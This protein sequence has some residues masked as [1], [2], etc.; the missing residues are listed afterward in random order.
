MQLFWGRHRD[1]GPPSPEGARVPAWRLTDGNGGP[2]LPQDGVSSAVNGLGSG[3]IEQPSNLEFPEWTRIGIRQVYAF[4]R[5]KYAEAYF[6]P[7]AG[8]RAKN[9]A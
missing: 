7:R 6:V 5:R 8:H 9:G 4:E 3:S 2:F 1:K